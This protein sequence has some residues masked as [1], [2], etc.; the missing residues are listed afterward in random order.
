MCDYVFL[1]ALLAMARSTY[2]QDETKL[3]AD[4]RKEGGALAKDCS[5]FKSFLSCGE[6]LFTGHPLHIAVGSI[7]P[8][9]GFGAGVAFVALRNPPK[10][11][12]RLTWNV[13]FRRLQQRILARWRL[14]ESGLQPNQE[15][16]HN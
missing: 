11:P 2:A 15:R 3:G 10:Q 5:S 8:Q 14:H 13:G 9:N 12:W 1:I 4:F 6:T 16:K 7:A